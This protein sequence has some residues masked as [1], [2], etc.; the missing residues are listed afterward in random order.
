MASQSLLNMQIDQGVNTVAALDRAGL[1]IRAAFWIFDDDAQTWRFSV[2]EPTV[3][4]RGPHAVY[5]QIAA[6]LNGLSG[7]LP[8]RDIYLRSAD[9]QLIALVQTAV[10]TPG[11]GIDAILFTGNAVMGNWIPDM[12]IYRMY[13]PPVA[14]T[15]P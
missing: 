9:D 5:E 4:V 12:Y 1:D 10:S 15:A 11:L 14:A 6:A 2:S 3:N 7:V 13:R 8:L